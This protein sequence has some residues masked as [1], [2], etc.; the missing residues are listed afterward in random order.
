MAV[1]QKD[2]A[3]TLRPFTL[4]AQQVMAQARADVERLPAVLVLV[5]RAL[6]HSGLADTFRLLPDL[7]LESAAR[8]AKAYPETSAQHHA[9]WAA[10]MASMIRK[11]R[12]RGDAAAGLQR[13]CERVG[14]RRASARVL[15][16]RL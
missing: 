4:H 11:K 6:E 12:G 10:I 7:D 9:L 8:G 1:Q 2:I 14:C 3:R 5:Q 16:P 13:H 15:Q